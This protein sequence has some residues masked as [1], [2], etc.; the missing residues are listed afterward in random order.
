MCRSRSPRADEIARLITAENGK[1]LMW[2][3]IEANAALHS[4][5]PPK[6]RA[7]GRGAAATGHRSTSTGRMGLG[8][9]LPIRACAGDRPF[10]FPLNLVAHKVAPAIAVGA[11]VITAGSPA[12]P[13]DFC[14]CWVSCSPRRSL[15]PA[16]GRRLLVT[17]SPPSW[18]P[19]RGFRSCPSPIRDGRLYIQAENPPN[20]ILKLGATPPRS[21]AIGRRTR[22]R[23]SRSPHRPVRQLPGRPVVCPCSACSWTSRC[24]TRSVLQLVA[25]SKRS[26]PG[27]PWG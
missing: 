7:A 21:W 27:R 9:A 16:C 18:S 14:C 17:R 2:S 25:V 6:R 13:A 5:G 20:T 3:R 26:P 19:I 8:A 24:T 1:P 12:N 11:P 23:I 15:R 4:A 10:N 22:T